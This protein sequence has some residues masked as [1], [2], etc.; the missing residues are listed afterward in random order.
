MLLGLGRSAVVL[1]IKITINMQSNQI[2]YE[3]LSRGV[4][5]HKTGPPTAFVAALMK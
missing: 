2:M 1:T 3:I 5:K 4:I